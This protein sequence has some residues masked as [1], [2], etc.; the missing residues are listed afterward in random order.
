[1][2]RYTTTESFAFDSNRE[3]RTLTIDGTVEI[4]SW[5]GVAFILAETKESGAYQIYTQGAR[6]E[7]V[8]TAG[9]SYTIDETGA[10]K[11]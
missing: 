5:D 11:A 2:S 6:L 3:Y 10:K 4:S 1:M 7:F 9:N 8:I